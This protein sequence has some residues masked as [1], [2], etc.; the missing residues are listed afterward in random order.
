MWKQG[1]VDE[2]V[3]CLFVGR[4]FVWGVWGVSTAA[5]LDVGGVLV[6]LGFTISCKVVGVCVWGGGC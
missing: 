1:S 6:L 2:E 5:G 3:C 4:W